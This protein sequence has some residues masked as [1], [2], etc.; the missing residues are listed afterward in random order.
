M[1]ENLAFITTIDFINGKLN[2]LLRSIRFFRLCRREDVCV[3]VGMASRGIFCRIFEL[4]VRLCFSHVYLCSIKSKDN[5]INNSRLRNIAIR[6]CDKEYVV[7]SDIDIVFDGETVDY[8]WQKTKA[9]GV[10]MLPCLY[11]S[12]FGSKKFLKYKNIKIGFNKWVANDEKYF[13]HLAIPSSFICT[14]REFVGKVGGFDEKYFGHGYEDFDFM[15]RLLEYLNNKEDDYWSDKDVAYDK[16]VTNICGFR[17]QLAAECLDE[18]KLGKIVIHLW[19]P[20]QKMYA[21]AREGN[22]L[23][24]HSKFNLNKKSQG[25]EIG[26]IVSETISNI[27]ENN[28]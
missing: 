8:I 5:L 10:A 3:Y 23:L 26:K 14:K 2:I 17:A 18:L 7:F 21:L 19:H 24:F 22:R 15:I 1:N 4:M 6:K 11:L 28:K 25:V 13:N 9:S 20:R 12:K 16:Q 27:R